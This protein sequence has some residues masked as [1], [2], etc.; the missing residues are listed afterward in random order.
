MQT[1][2]VALMTLRTLNGSLIFERFS[3]LSGLLGEL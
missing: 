1:F 3:A 2:K